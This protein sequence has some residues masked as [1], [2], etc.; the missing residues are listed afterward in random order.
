A[1]GAQLGERRC[2]A[3]VLFHGEALDITIGGRALHLDKAIAHVE[4]ESGAAKTA[5]L[6]APMPGKI[7]AI[8]A[9]AGDAVT[10]G[11]KLMVMEAMKMELAITAPADSIVADVAVAVGEQVPEGTVLIRF[12]SEENPS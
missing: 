3:L 7:L 2:H 5:Q 9:R 10:K 1:L 8:E 4:D 6:A 12:E 11:Q